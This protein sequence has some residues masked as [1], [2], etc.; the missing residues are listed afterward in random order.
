MKMYKWVPVCHLVKNSRD[1]NR[2]RLFDED[3]RASLGMDEDSNMS[4]N[5]GAS[6]SNDGSQTPQAEKE[7]TEKDGKLNFFLL[8]CI[9]IQLRL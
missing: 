2:R 7:K 3:S 9:F 6:D 4:V 8:F 1:L 5:S